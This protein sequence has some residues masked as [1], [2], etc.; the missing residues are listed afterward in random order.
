MIRSRFA[1]LLFVGTSLAGMPALAQEIPTSPPADFS[2]GRTP[3][4][5]SDLPYLMDSYVELL[6][7]DPDVMT[8][9]YDYVV[10]ATQN[11]TDEQTLAA[12]HDDRTNQ[13][14]SVMN[15]LGVL[16]SIVMTGTG[17][18]ADGTTPASL[19]PTTYAD[20]TIAD[21]EAD[22]NY[23]NGASWGTTT[24]ADGTATPLASAVTF[25]QDIVRADAS[26]EP[27]KRTFDRL[28]ENN[29]TYRQYESQYQDYNVISNPDALTTEDTADF[30][31]PAYLSNYDVPEEYGTV[32]NWVRGF[33]VTQEMIDENGGEPITVEGLGLW[34]DGVFT[35]ATFGVG[36]YVPGI[37][38]SPRPYRV[39]DNVA[40]PELLE[41]VANTTN[42]YADGSMPS[43]HTSSAWTEALGLA[44]L[45]PQEMQSLVTRASELGEDR[46]LAGEHSPL[47]VIGGRIIAEAIAAT[48]IYD[49]LYDDEGNRL[50]WTDPANE[51][52]YAVYTAYTE[53]QAYI[54][55]ACGTATVDECVALGGDGTS[56]AYGTAEAN[57]AA[58]LYRM[59][60]GFEATSE[61]YRM[62]VSD[63]PVQAQVLLLTR[64]PYLTD[65]QRLEVLASTALDADYPLISGNTYDGWGKL[66]LYDAAD[67]YGYFENDVT[68]TMDA[69]LGGYNAADTWANDIA[70]PGGL[71]KDGTGKLTLSGQDTYTGDTVVAGGTLAIDGS[72]VSNVRVQR[73]AV[74]RGVGVIGGGVTV[75]DGGTLAPGNSPGTLTVANSVTL[76]D[77]A[78][79]EFDIDGTG[80]EIGAGNYSRLELVGEDSIFTADGELIPLLR[81]I[82]G[83]ATN[84]YT[85]DIGT[86]FQ[87]V[88]AEGGVAG[89][90]DSL[91]QPDGLADGT[92][93]DTIYGSNDLR[94][95]VTPTAYEDY[96]ASG[97]AANVAE[98][99]D[100]GRQAAGIRLDDDAASLYDALYALSAAD[101][102]AALG[103]LAPQAYGDALLVNR[104]SWYLGSDAVNRAIEARRG[105][106]VDP[107]MQSA[108]QHGMT[109][110]LT[111]LGQK[112]SID[113]DPA[114]GYDQTLGGLIVGLDGEMGDGFLLGASLGYVNLDAD[115]DQGAS[116]SGDSLQ[117]RIYGSYRR[118]IAFVDGQFGFAYTDG[119]V[120]RGVAGFGGM[121]GDADST[122]FGGEIRT[123]LRYGDEATS[124]EPSIALRGV[125]V[126]LDGATESGPAAVSFDDQ[127]FDSLQSVL[128][129]GVSH[130]I[131]L[132][133]GMSLTPAA[134]IG[135]SHEFSDT[136]GA[137]TAAFVGAPGASFET[138]GAS[139]GRDAALVGVS[140]EFANGGAG[141]VFASYEGAFAENQSSHSVTAGL[142]F[143]W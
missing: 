78:M 97:N 124:F 87:I 96:A 44:F 29:D 103:D 92:R 65:E 138:V 54:A 15:G 57:K 131:A 66:N 129:L 85:P 21:Y 10:T 70:G 104:D 46:I 64:F 122:S 69:S 83:D 68:V 86:Q 27:S 121:H 43:G 19:T 24:F 22:I 39:S 82:T 33:T 23:L 116:F 50:D 42:P 73:R 111:A 128:A 94:L 137:V 11:R 5:P 61:P 130:R 6:L 108:A 3:D 47:D 62:A 1:S 100:A 18:S 115:L 110:W 88:V 135:W 107:T 31:I 30:I 53:T 32:E 140:A 93:F 63:V 75:E 51:E 67:G 71:V 56:V 36:D 91:T 37:G 101:L 141:S 119:E 120:D 12:I 136:D 16:T 49:A 52:A 79:S 14:Y 38:T 112:A 4:D 59:T 126:Q 123:G 26:T 45:V 102:P 134:R 106:V 74:L 72:I 60:Y 98:A 125:S 90:Y 113:S 139:I 143:S 28:M 84:S 41:Q 118:G 40:V 7:D 35:P 20:A 17:A 105:G 48:N 117:G 132:A 13:Q 142:K 89:S 95:V 58:F 9:N 99:L 81:G 25:I 80:T 109:A 133:D 114:S 76:S 55:E 8:Q 34:T 77:G 2:N 127:S